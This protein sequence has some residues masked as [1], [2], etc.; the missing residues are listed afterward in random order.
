MQQYKILFKNIFDHI[1]F[2]YKFKISD[3]RKKWSIFYGLK[4][5]IS[6]KNTFNHFLCLKYNNNSKIENLE[7]KILF[8]VKNVKN[9]TYIKFFLVKFGDINILYKL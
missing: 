5:N 8:F 1:N 9:E 7:I 4:Y 6:F 3:Y 2:L